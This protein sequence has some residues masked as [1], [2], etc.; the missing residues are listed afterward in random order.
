MSLF[1]DAGVPKKSDVEGTA[2][3]ALRCRLRATLE[4]VFGDLVRNPSEEDA[5]PVHDNRFGDATIRGK[6]MLPKM[7]ETDK[8]MAEAEKKKTEKKKPPPAP[9]DSDS[10]S[11]SDSSSSSS[12]S[13]DSSDDDATPTPAQALLARQA[14][15]KAPSSSSS[16]SEDDF[17]IPHTETENLAAVLEK[18]VEPRMEFKKGNKAEGWATQ[19]GKAVKAP[20]RR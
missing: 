8:K 3:Y 16:D 14:V 17:L 12:S 15:P 7:A 19:K 5:S 10:D 9:A 2:Q 18:V 4:E 13:S 1:K 11:D 20:G 6:D